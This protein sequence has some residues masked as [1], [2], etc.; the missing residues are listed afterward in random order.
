MSLLIH[1]LSY[2]MKV[3]LDKGY[4]CMN[5]CQRSKAPQAYDRE[6][7]GRIFTR[8]SCEFQVCTECD[9]PEHSNG[10]CFEYKSRL[11]ADH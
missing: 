2:T 7:N 11:A 10:T 8:A 3:M 4:I 1:R 5:R 6:K 9:R